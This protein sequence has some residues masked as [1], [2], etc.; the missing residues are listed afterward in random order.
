MVDSFGS[1]TPLPP[2]ELVGNRISEKRLFEARFLFKK[3]S[4]EIDPA[5]RKQLQ[6]QLASGI[7]KA[8]QSFAAGEQ[9]ERA[10]DLEKAMAAY[11]DVAALVVD[12]PGLDEAQ[13]RV[14]LA[15]QLGPL[16]S[17]EPVEPEVDFDFLNSTPPVTPQASPGQPVAGVSFFQQ[18]KV[19]LGLVFFLF[20]MLGLVTG[21]MYFSPE[22]TLEVTSNILPDRVEE[23]I[24][25][26][27]ADLPALQPVSEIE[28]I[29][30]VEKPVLRSS[31]LVPP[32]EAPPV[33]LKG[34]V[35][36]LENEPTANDD[37]I[38]QSNVQ[39]QP[40]LPLQEPKAEEE[41]LIEKQAGTP[42]EL[43]IP[44]LAAELEDAEVVMPG[45]AEGTAVTPIQNA[46]NARKDDSTVLQLAGKEGADHEENVE[47]GLDIPS[48]PPIEPEGMSRNEESSEQ[49]GASRGQ[50][51]TDI[52][53]EQ[54]PTA[55][56][57]SEHEEITVVPSHQGEALL[58]RSS[59]H[60]PDPARQDEEKLAEAKEDGAEKSNLQP[61]PP[62]GSTEPD[63]DVD[64]STPQDVPAEP[65]SQLIDAVPVAEA[66]V[67]K[68]VSRNNKKYTVCSGDTLETIARKVYGDR[69]KWSHLVA[70]NQ[71]KLG[72][73][74]Y[75]LSVGMQ[76]EVPPLEVKKGT[77]LL[78]NDGTYTVQSGDSL[79][80]IARKIYG[81]SSKWNAL[82]KLNRDK[83]PTPGALKVGQV[84]RVNKEGIV[85]DDHRQPKE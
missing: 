56:Q 85:T 60:E 3:F 70:A 71:E 28:I 30:P 51:Q 54:H 49:E 16:Q 64:V 14:E 4:Q 6:Q 47:E 80:S 27:V 44:Q 72:R 66:P 58:V 18:K 34:E 84:L 8:E 35:V 39:V 21:W 20:C 11:A 41:L 76:L 17:V 10:D 23:N 82:Y 31:Q 48:P 46:W 67:D 50:G 73:P 12:Y 57:M 25:E 74:P 1:R 19:L 37:R 22:K 33:T 62:D 53:I 78:N 38:P 42:S 40:P 36:T 29:S 63:P 79:G 61:P 52:Q 75:L 68:P 83:L 7:S 2:A 45:G 81:N 26:S 32:D 13:Q 43:I 24:S 59:P 69:Y 15:I 9:L 5:A 65:E 77:D 55:L